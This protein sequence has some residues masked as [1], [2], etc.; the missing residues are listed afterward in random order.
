MSN[1]LRARLGLERSDVTLE[2]LQ[3]SFPLRITWSA[4]H[5]RSDDVSPQGQLLQCIG[6]PSLPLTDQRQFA[7][8]HSKITLPHRVAGIGGGE[9]LSDGEAVAVGLERLVKLALRLEHVADIAVRDRQIVLV[10]LGWAAASRS[11]MARLSR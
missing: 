2:L 8:A 9:P 10:L 1:L 3:V 5:Q 6:E 4:A 7:V 11:A